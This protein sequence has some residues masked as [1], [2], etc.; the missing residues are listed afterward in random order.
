MKK[1]RG[2]AF[3]LALMLILSVAVFPA[4]ADYDGHGGDY[5]IV[6]GDG[7]RLRT[8]A[9]SG[10]DNNVLGLLFKGD[11][12]NIYGAAEGSGV[13]WAYGQVVSG[14]NAGK[15]GYVAVSYLDLYQQ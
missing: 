13:M 9:Y 2:I 3:I 12:I 6:N 4:A 14:G 7:V 10:D 8:T 15:W 5:G 1:N 11:R